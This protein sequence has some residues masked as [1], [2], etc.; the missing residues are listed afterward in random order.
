MAI[1]IIS[2]ALLGSL[3]EHLAG[4]AAYGQYKIGSTW[5]TSPIDLGEVKQNGSVCIAFL[6]EAKDD[7]LSP[8]EQFRLCAANNDILAEREEQISFTSDLR[9][10]IYRF[11]FEIT[12][13]EGTE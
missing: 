9:R 2:N 11:R 12:A 3:R 7:G 8:A 4:M 1:T 6:I 13:G 10:L 5:Y